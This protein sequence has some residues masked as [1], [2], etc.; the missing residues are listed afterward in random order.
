MDWIGNG[1]GTGNGNENLD[2]M[3]NGMEMGMEMKIWI[4]VQSP[5]RRHHHHHHSRLGEKRNGGGRKKEKKKERWWFYGLRIM[6]M[7]WN[8]LNYMDAAWRVAA[9]HYDGKMVMMTM[10]PLTLWI[11]LCFIDCVNV[12]CGLF[13]CES[14]VTPMRASSHIGGRTDWWRA[15]PTPSCVTARDDASVTVSHWSC[16]ARNI[17]GICVVCKLWMWSFNSSKSQCVH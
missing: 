5:G 6:M 9:I 17:M 2:V 7:E 13:V 10:G 14:H 12:L 11:V 1:I 8:G 15:W 3:R 4:P 16:I